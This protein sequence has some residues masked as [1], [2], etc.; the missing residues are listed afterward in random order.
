ML[1]FS[2]ENTKVVS[3]INDKWQRWELCY[4][5]DEN[6]A[7]GYKCKEH[8]LFQN[9]VIA[10]TLSKDIIVE[11]TPKFEGIEKHPLCKKN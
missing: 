9:D 10:C 3:K 7:P 6:Y 2:L 8:N 11:D 5:C 1:H 4:N